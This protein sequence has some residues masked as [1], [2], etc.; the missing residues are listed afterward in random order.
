MNIII[1]GASRGIGLE[2]VKHFAANKENR[3]VAV[4]RNIKPLEDI[5][6]NNNVYP[7]S[8]DLTALIKDETILSSFVSEIFSKTD[9]I[10]NNAG[11]LKAEN[12]VSSDVNSAIEM[13]NVNYFGLSQV[14]KT[15]YE[16][17]KQADN[18]HIVNISSMG[19]FQGSAKFAGLSHYSASKAAVVSLTEVLA[20]EFKKD[21]IKVNALALGAVETEMLNE[22]F[23]GYKAPICA[24][25]MAAFICNFAQET[26][27]Y[28]NGKVVPVS[29]STP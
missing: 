21:N 15:M 6:K 23:P 17:L 24:K 28:I 18:P 3:V 9:I 7:I 5:S 11:Y 29:L 12:F 2:M 4:S 8:L 16:S 10:I 27:R 25:D 26:H 1:T 19:G 14:I 22:A 20:E 13:F